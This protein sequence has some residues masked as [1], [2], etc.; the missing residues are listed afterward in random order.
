VLLDE[1]L[2]EYDVSKRHAIRIPAPPER[3]YEALRSRAVGRS[4]TSR[5]LMGLRGYG[6]RMRAARRGESLVENLERLGF[7]RLGERTGEEIVFGLVGRFWRLDGGLR[8][9]S[10]AEFAAFQEPGFA[11]AAWNLAVREIGPGASE[12]STETRV[13]CLGPEARRRF[14]RYWR[15]VEPFSGLIRRSLLRNVRRAATE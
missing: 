10:A 8:S 12:L 6:R 13:L 3:V 11:K 9:L 4:L 15:V 1:F 5:V 7:A 14:L 2:P